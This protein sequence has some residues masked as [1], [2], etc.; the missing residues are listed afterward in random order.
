MSNMYSFSR[1]FFVAI[2]IFLFSCGSSPK[3]SFDATEVDNSPD[4]SLDKNWA[5]LPDREDN[6]DKTPLGLNDEQETAGADVFFLHPTIYFGKKE[7]DKWNPDI[8]NNELNDNVDDT[9]ILYQASA[10]NKAGRVYAPRY[11]QAHLQAYYTKDTVSAKKAF[12]LAYEDVQAAFAYYLSHY[13]KG[14]PIILASHSQGTTHAS[15]LLEDYFDGKPLE[16]RLVAAYLIGIPID[17]DRYE[18]LKPCES[19]YDVSCLIGWRTWK[20][21]AKPKFLKK[22][23]GKNILVTNPLSWKTT[24]EY[25]DKEIHG[26]SLFFDFDEELTPKTQDAQIYEGILWTNKPKFKGSFLMTSKNYHRGDINLFYK[27]IRDN[28]ARRVSVF[29]KKQ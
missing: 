29:T 15:R 13:N 8:D 5:A 28:A 19:E 18:S 24:T 11:R 16:K 20:N 27:N 2:I 3:G 12:D 1:L 4:Y 14:R 9:P 6:A 7:W 17:L 10:F 22:E 25:V 26:G 21:G 23:I